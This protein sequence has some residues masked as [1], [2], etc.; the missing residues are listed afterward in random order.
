MGYSTNSSPTKSIVSKKN[1]VVRSAINSSS[2][3]FNSVGKY[4]VSS[5]NS[6]L[7]NEIKG[8]TQKFSISIWCKRAVIDGTYQTIFSRDN[9]SGGRQFAC[10]FDPAEEWTFFIA[11]SATKY[12]WWKTNQTFTNTN[13]WYH[14]VMTFDNTLALANKCIIYINGETATTTRTDAGGGVSNVN[15]NSSEPIYINVTDFGV[16][17]NPF[18]G[19]TNR[20]SFYNGILSQSDVTLLYNNSQPSN[21]N[22]IATSIACYLNWNFSLASFSSN[23]TLIDSIGTPYPSST[24]F[25]S[26]GMSGSDRVN[27]YPTHQNFN[28]ASSMLFASMATSPTN[29]RKE[30]IDAFITNCIND[31]NWQLMDVCWFMAASDSQAAKLNWKSPNNYSLSPIGSPAFSIDQGF[32]GNGSTNAFDSNWNPSVNGINYSLNSGCIGT[33]NRINLNEATAS[34][35]NLSGTLASLIV[36][37]N[38]G[39]FAARVNSNTNTT[40][41]SAN[42]QGLTVISRNSTNSQSI[43]QNGSLLTSGTSSST[44]VANNTI[45]ILAYNNTGALGLPSNNQVAFAFAGSGII[46][47][48]KLYMRVQQ[49]LKSLGS[50][51]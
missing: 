41:A 45:Y 3:F 20:I 12:S 43:Y 26:V 31:G 4:F 34:I 36:P 21:E 49:Y 23:W 9:S 38:G 42:S 51:V 46:D 13:I 47:Q 22:N 48:T 18:G 44:G 17:E 28:F 6:L 19:Y 39:S 15:D 33:Y 5:S 2:L 24:N 29:R 10:E 16:L 30:F 25:T 50:N 27:I 40:F 7:N 1:Y 37:R 11:D 35:G 8:T 32:A 14:L